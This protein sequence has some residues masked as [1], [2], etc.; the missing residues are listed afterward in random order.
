MALRD[1]ALERSPIKAPAM[2][3]SLG[4]I[5]VLSLGT[6]LSTWKEAFE[7]VFGDATTPNI[8]AAVLIA[9]IA[10]IAVVASVDMLARAL[11]V[12][13]DHSNVL[14]FAK[15]WPSTLVKAGPDEDGFAI[16]AVRAGDSGAEYLLVKDGEGPQWH[17]EDTVKPGSTPA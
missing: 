4:T 2:N 9:T 14:T 12:R 1:R 17:R 5:G 15:G 6:V 16:V 7:F 10:G 8:R 11:S 13:I 3:I